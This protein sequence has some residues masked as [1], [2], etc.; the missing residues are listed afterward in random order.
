LRIFI[1]KYEEIV[2]R[3]LGLKNEDVVGKFMDNIEN[4]N[5]FSLY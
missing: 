3:L 5:M 1:E 4:L 2:S